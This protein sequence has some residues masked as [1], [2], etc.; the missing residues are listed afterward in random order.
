MSA[1]FFELANRAGVTRIADTTG[2]DRLGIP[3][4]SCVMPRSSDSITVYSGK[5]E[6]WDLAVRRAVMEAIERTACLWNDS[7][8]VVNSVRGQIECNDSVVFSPTSFTERHLGFDENTPIAWTQCRAYESAYPS[9]GASLA[10]VPAE[11]VFGGMRPPYIHRVYPFVTSNGLGASLD[12]YEAA[13]A[14]ALL[15][16]YERDAISKMEL[17]S[18]DY[19]AFALVSIAAQLGIELDTTQS[20]ALLDVDVVM[21]N[22]M[23]LDL[24]T[25]PPRIQKL[26][27]R[28]ASAGLELSVRV[29]ASDL[30][31]PVV[32]A[33]CVERMGP[34]SFQ[35][36]AGYAA[37]FEL[38]QAVVDAL[39]ELAQSRA[40]DRQGARE[41]CCNADKRR[42][43]LDPT[44]RH[45]LFVDDRAH[46]FSTLAMARADLESI[47]AARS[48][49]GLG[50]VLTKSF[51]NEFQ[52]EVVRVLVPGIETWHATDGES[53]AGPR[54]R[55][56]IERSGFNRGGG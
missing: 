38:E 32:G 21:S 27:R 17:L 33:A 43:Q 29:I 14:H 46:P 30:G 44:G 52:A 47:I 2:L 6:T 11:L 39:L 50:P 23:K 53:G 41:D 37:R 34:M 13:L 22:S 15:E 12:S 40:T 9:N 20:S 45:W 16:L 35:C 49:V 55:A 26:A 8:V 56:L 5:G 3:T 36:A 25:T 7:D 19:T 4:A 10:W 31:V 1:S 51:S 42:L 28:F 54:L 18:R 24:D 48:K